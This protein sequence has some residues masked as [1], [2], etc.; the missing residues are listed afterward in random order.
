MNAI[1]LGE[2]SPNYL[3]IIGQGILSFLTGRIF[4]GFCFVTMI[5]SSIV[6]GVYYGFSDGPGF[7]VV[8]ALCGI[9]VSLITVCEV[10][11][12]LQNRHKDR[13]YFDPAEYFF[14]KGWGWW[15]AFGPAC[16]TL[17][18]F[19][20]F[21][22]WS[23][24][25]KAVV[26]DGKEVLSW[27]WALPYQGNIV[28]VKRKQLVY[29]EKS[30][31]TTKDGIQVRG[32]VSAEFVLGDEPALW[33]SDDDLQSKAKAELKRKLQEAIA[34]M[35]TE[36]LREVIFLEASVADTARVKEIGLKWKPGSVIEVS[37]IHAAPPGS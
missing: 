26:I 6:A 4:A 30:L 20:H 28:V 23:N 15:L 17:F 16:V 19:S 11:P 2:K 14:S 12:I 18:V 32:N 31:A 1:A 24:T 3:K 8:L 22:F 36:K 5:L 7:S 9:L 25:K 37:H 10:F 13:Y 27:Q 33:Q 21:A 29:V 34:G 35:P